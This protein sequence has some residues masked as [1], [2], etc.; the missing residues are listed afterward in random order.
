MQ[1]VK[2]HDEA[3]QMAA[4]E[5]VTLRRSKTLMI[6]EAELKRSDPPTFEDE[7]GILG[8]PTAEA[9]PTAKSDGPSA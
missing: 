1:K 3:E 2:A 9:D 5:K 8:D 4:A 6:V 7:P